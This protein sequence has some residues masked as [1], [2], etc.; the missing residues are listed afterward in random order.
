MTNNNVEDLSGQLSAQIIDQADAFTMYGL[1][2]TA[3]QALFTFQ[4]DVGIASSISEVFIDDG[5]IVGQSSVHNSLGGFTDFSGGGANPGDLPGGNALIPAFEA[6]SA[7]SADAQ[8][9]PSKGVDTSADILGIV[10]DLLPAVTFADVAD[11][12]DTGEL[13]IGYHIRSIG[14]QGGSDSYVNDGGPG[15]GPNPGPTPISEPGTFGLFTMSLI[16]LGIY[17]RKKA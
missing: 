12:L 2:I 1:N 8:G 9:H 11:A 10:Y 15:P 4:N 7:Y 17:R 5:T 6:T 13:R 14:A 3:D 16:L